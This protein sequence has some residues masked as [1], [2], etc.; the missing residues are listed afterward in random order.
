[1][2]LD[3]PRGIPEL[4]H[5]IAAHFAPLLVEEN[6]LTL[7]GDQHQA[8]PQSVGAASEGFIPTTDTMKNAGGPITFRREPIVKTVP[9]LEEGPLRAKA[10]EQIPTMPPEEVG[11][12]MGAPPLQGNIPLREQLTPTGNE[13]PSR[14]LTLEQK[15]PDREVRQ[16]VHAN[17]EDIVQAA[18]NDRETLK[19]IHDLKNTDVR[20]AMIN[21]GEDMG[22]QSIGNRKAMGESQLSR[23]DAFK[24]LLAKGYTPK[25]IVELAQQTSDSIPT[26]AKPG[27]MRYETIGERAKREKAGD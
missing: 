15:Y 16:L 11:R 12:L 22:Q 13:P 25:Q 10:G 18:G 9:G 17:G 20:Q 7:R 14:Q 23:Q 2:Q 5:K 24:R 4:V 26:L 3:E 6:V 1:M 27:P 8:E 19:A 21:S